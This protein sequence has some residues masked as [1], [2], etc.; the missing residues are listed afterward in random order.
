MITA[1]YVPPAKP[2]I[3]LTAVANHFGVWPANLATR[4]R[5]H[6]RWLTLAANYAHAAPAFNS[7]T[8]LKPFGRDR[9]HR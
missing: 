6:P 3:S 4:A 7:S 8:L 9:G 2:E 5:T 1:T